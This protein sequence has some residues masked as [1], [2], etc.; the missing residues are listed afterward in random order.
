MTR[1]LCRLAVVAA[2]LCVLSL[3]LASSAL[4]ASDPD[5][6]TFTHEGCRLVTTTTLPGPDGFV[7]SDAEYTTGNLGKNWNELDNVPFRLTGNNGGADQTYTV[8]VTAD[9]FDGGHPGYD[10]VSI[11]VLNT[12]LSTGGAAHAAD[13]CSLV[14]TDPS[15][16]NKFGAILTPGVGGTDKS[17][18]RKLTIFQKAGATCVFDWYARLALGSH[19]YPGSSLHT[20]LVNQDF[21]TGGIGAKDVSIPVKEILPQD[22]DKTM[23]ARQGKAY[24]WGVTKTGT[25]SVNF[26]DTC[27]PDAPHSAT[28]TSAITW[29]RSAPS[30]NADITVTTTITVTNPSHRDVIANVTDTVY[31]GTTAVTTTGG[32]SEPNP[33]SFAP[34]TV[35]PNNTATLTNTIHVASGTT[36]LNDIAQATYTDPVDP[37]RLIPGNTEATASAAVETSNTINQSATIVDNETITGD[38]LS[39]AIDSIDNEP[40]GSSIT[41]PVGYVVGANTKTTSSTWQSG[42]IDPGA[43]TT[44]VSGTITFHKTI[45]L[46]GAHDI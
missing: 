39:Y 28:V 46:D 1:T 23:T 24:G 10:V 6:V 5:H 13:N 25:P 42:T 40:A 41:A 37:D 29:T 34:V 43:G 2:S 22:L 15:A 18:Y 17:I 7:C 8:A 4:A 21:G 20:N 12:R 19:L 44:N 26:N 32:V 33:K 3:A 11:P 36:N 31:S 45:Y 27:D 35:H 30:A 16:A 38:G 14:S 9:N